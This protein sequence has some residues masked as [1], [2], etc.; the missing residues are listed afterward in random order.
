MWPTDNIWA[1]AL[2]FAAAGSAL[3]LVAFLGSVLGRSEDGQRAM[4][5]ASIGLGFLIALYVVVAISISAPQ[6]DNGCLYAPSHPS[7]C[8]T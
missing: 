5:A 8:R 4:K 6:P 7:D 1:N 3:I 2:I